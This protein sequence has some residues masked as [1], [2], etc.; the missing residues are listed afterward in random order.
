M[1][2]NTTGQ[3]GDGTNGFRNSP[4]QVNGIWDS[5]FTVGGYHT[6]ARK[7]DGTIWAWGD[8]PEGQLGNNTVVNS[9]SPVQVGAEIT[10]A[11]VSAGWDH[12]AGR[13]TDGSIWAWGNNTTGQ[14][15]DGTGFIDLPQQVNY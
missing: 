10:W 5:V 1:G 7:A 3:L 15:G 13:K 8:N 4:V 12:T 11:S 6:L 14:L 9:S 2:N